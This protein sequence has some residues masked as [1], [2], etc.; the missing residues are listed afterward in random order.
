M[1]VDRGRD[2][3]A[4]EAQLQVQQSVAPHEWCPVVL[5]P[6]T[7]LSTMRAYKHSISSYSNTTCDSLHMQVNTNRHGNDIVGVKYIFAFNI[8]GMTAGTA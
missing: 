1:K 7:G 5:L 8:R 6:P 3:A 4:K 2:M